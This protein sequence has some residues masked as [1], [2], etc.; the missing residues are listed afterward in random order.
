M[1]YA[2]RISL[3]S[4]LPLKGWDQIRGLLVIT[5]PR[6]AC[7]STESLLFMNI[8]AWGPQVKGLRFR[9]VVQG[10]LEN[11]FKKLRDS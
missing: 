2:A 9:I 11:K 8:I 7:H 1:P 3:Y 4:G 6:S 10:Q 5:G